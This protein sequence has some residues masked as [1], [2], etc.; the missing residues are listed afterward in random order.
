MEHDFDLF[1]LGAGSGGVRASRMAAGRGA[2][3]AVAEDDRLGGTCV[4]VG[5]IPKKLFVLASHFSEDFEDAAGYGWSVGPRSFDWP[6][7]IANKDKE[8]TRL[9]GIYQRML[10]GAGVT[11]ISGR[12][13]IADAHTVEVGEQR[14][15]AEHIL[16]AV[17]SWPHMPSIPGIEHAISSNE[18]FYLEQ[19]PKRAAIV[20]GGYIGV[21]FAGIF[22]GL[23]VETT[24][25]YR[26]PLFLRGFDDDLR[27][28]LAEEMPKKGIHLRFETD[29]AEIRREDDG[30]HLTL[31]DGS[32]LVVDQILYATGR[33]PK[34]KD[35]GLEKAGVKLGKIGEILVDPYSRS[36]VPSIWAL[37][38]VTDRLNLTPMAIAEAMAFVRTVFGDDP[39]RPDHADVATAVFSQPPIG[40]VG[41]TEA[42]ARERFGNIDVYRSTFRPLKHTL[43][44][45]DEQTMMKLLVDPK[46]DRVVGAHMIGADAAEILQGVGIA[47]KLGA[48]KAQFDETIGIH[49]TSAEEFVTM[50][51]KVQEG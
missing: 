39:T 36:N 11:H 7:L 9:N 13:T 19:L 38:D 24:Q 5:C 28:T 43:T 33:V 42:E 25:I 27:K 50:R 49:P 30:L 44:G 45:R 41:L 51:E 2:R 17:G 48:T 4:N 32:S 26:G 16:V 23:G 37:G 3:V 8:I 21:E 20:G 47:V 31:S 35:I 40:T 15:T 34:T 12:A 10:D 22:N 6:T 29:V 46:T 1:V 18:A 14:Y